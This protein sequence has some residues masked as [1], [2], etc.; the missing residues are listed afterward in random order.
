M[1]PL[2]ALAISPVTFM[3]FVQ[4]QALVDFVK[5]HGMPHNTKMLDQRLREKRQWMAYKQRLVSQVVCRGIGHVV[6]TWRTRGGHVVD[7]WWVRGGHVAST[8]RARGGHLT[9]MLRACSGH[10][11]AL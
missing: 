1:S 9:G 5:C 10:V 6:D 4:G 3:H 2:Q 8:W 11:T 7:T